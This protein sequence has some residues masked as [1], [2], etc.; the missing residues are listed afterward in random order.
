MTRSLLA[1]ALLALALP[2][3]L[4]AQV[5]TAPPVVTSWV[6]DVAVLERPGA[7]M[8]GIALV[9]D[10]GSAADRPGR[11]GE[12][13]IFAHLLARTVAEAAPADRSRRADVSIR[14]DRL[15]LR[16]TVEARDVLPTLVD[17]EASLSLPPSV[18]E[19]EVLRSRL[20]ST[21][22]F[23]R[24][25]PVTEM[26]L[27]RR[28]LVEG[29]GTPWSRS[30]TGTRVS[31]EGLTLQD[32]VAIAAT[33]R[34]DDLHLGVV[35]AVD[36]GELQR[37]FGDVDGSRVRVGAGEPE[38]FADAPF[39]GA[40][41]WLT[42]DRRRIVRQVT[43]TWITVAFPVPSDMPATVVDF[44]AHR[45]REEIQTQPPDPGLFDADVRIERRPAG[46]MIVVDAAVLPDGT[47]RWEAR[48]LSTPEVASEPVQDAFFHWL[49][50]R[51]RA[52]VLLD[53]AAP[54]IAA[55]RLALDL[56]LGLPRV[57]DIGE[58]AWGLSPELLER[59]AAALGE[60]RIL[61]YGPDLGNER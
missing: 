6:A 9:I 8:A 38:E 54:E 37:H 55:A 25:S 58:E 26:E 57:R 49:R 47:D 22:D 14:A 59:A 12:R 15:E 45:M 1:A 31:V 56:V 19:F 51:F 24:G 3:G 5:S 53:E 46:R 7:P 36:A 27:E 33:V 52:R 21:F 2:V 42:A 16:W 35:G 17:V 41:P 4:V 10:G 28:A 50:R 32:I 18:R 23:T 40:L 39:T 44:L 43:N 48:I 13:W 20:L 60:P 61:V 34:P 30:P 11:E 29:A